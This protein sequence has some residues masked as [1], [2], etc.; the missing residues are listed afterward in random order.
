MNH[1]TF[2]LNRVIHSPSKFTNFMGL[3]HPILK[4]WIKKYT[5]KNLLFVISALL[6][7]IWAILSWGLNATGSV[8][9]LLYAAVIVVLIRVLFNK[10]L[11][12]EKSI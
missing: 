8:N 5:M 2:I 3:I 10:K 1:V 7:I 12:G 11:F 4:W 6:L 9:L